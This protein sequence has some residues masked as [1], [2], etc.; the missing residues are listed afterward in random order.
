MKVAKLYEVPDNDFRFN[1]KLLL[2]RIISFNLNFARNHDK[3]K[4]VIINNMIPETIVCFQEASG[5]MYL[6]FEQYLRRELEPGTQIFA[7]PLHKKVR[8]SIQYQSIIVSKVFDVQGV[9]N[10]RIKGIG[11]D[12]NKYIQKVRFEFEGQK[13]TLLNVHEFVQSFHSWNLPK[14]SLES[15][16]GKMDKN[17]INLMVGDFNF[18]VS[19]YRRMLRKCGVLE[20]SHGVKQNF[21][22]SFQNLLTTILRKPLDLTKNNFKIL[23]YKRDAFMISTKKKF[24]DKVR[25][26]ETPYS[27]HDLMILDI[28]FRGINT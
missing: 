3:L 21:T 20:L 9:D 25:N 27:D 16:F 2:M 19:N 22:L 1:T 18:N 28:E 17:R 7:T 4:D 15:M 8:G 12:P 10:F 6:F 23:R 26:I 14:R 5:S 13:F 24:T 11:S